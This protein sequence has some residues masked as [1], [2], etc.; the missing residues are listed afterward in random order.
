MASGHLACR[1]CP[2]DAQAGRS[3]GRKER[4]YV[5]RTGATEDVA[6]G[7]HARPSGRVL[8]AR[9]PLLGAV[10]AA[11]VQAVGRERLLDFLDRLPTEV[12]DRRELILS[13]GDEIADRLEIGRAHV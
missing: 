3:Q 11:Q 10:L 8:C 9:G 7:L 12:G 4:S 5:E 6:S 13:L 1:S 2:M